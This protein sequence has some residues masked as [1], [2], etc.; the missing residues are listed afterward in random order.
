MPL[1]NAS[2]TSPSSSIFSSFSAIALSPPEDPHPARER[3]GAGRTVC[4][5]GSHQ[6]HVRRFGT[7][8]SLTNFELDL[9]ALGEGLVALARNRRMVDEDVLLALGRSDEA[10]ALRVVEPLDGSGCHK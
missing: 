2:T 8:C 6:R 1:R 4:G 9:S 10:V 5:L 3:R 7:L